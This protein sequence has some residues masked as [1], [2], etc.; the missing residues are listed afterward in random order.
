MHQ[1]ADEEGVWKADGDGTVDLLGGGL[2]GRGRWE[3]GVERY[4]LG[5]TISKL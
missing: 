4:V 5:S 2:V 1:G 3:M